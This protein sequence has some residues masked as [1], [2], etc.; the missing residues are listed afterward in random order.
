[1]NDDKWRDI[2][3]KIKENFQVESHEKRAGE[4]EGENLEEIVFN[5]PAGPMKLL[6]II[7]PRLVGEKTKYSNRI[8][9]STQVEKIYSD[10]ETVDSVRLYQQKDGEW[11][12]IDTTPL[13][14]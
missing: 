13:F 12:E 2:I 11:G 9:S 14:Q 4:Y 10:T 6:R 1:M 8:G 3:D 7:K 5:H